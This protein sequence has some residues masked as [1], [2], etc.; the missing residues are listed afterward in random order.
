MSTA[1]RLHLVRHAETLFN[2]RRQL[3]GW[4]DSPLTEHGERQVAALGERMRDVPLTAAFMSD[5]T[6]TRTTMAAALRHHPSIEPVPLVELREWN[7]GGFEG[8][9]ND[10]LWDPVF[11]GLGADY[12]DV[13]GTWPA[14]TEN[15]F[16]SLLDAIAAA[17]PMGRA[18]TGVQV[19]ERIESGLATV[20]RA[21]ESGGDVLVVTH[22]SVM[23]SILRHLVPAHRMLPGFPNCGVV[24]VEWADGAGTVGE[25]D[26]SCSLPE[27]AAAAR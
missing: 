12:A 6:R 7:F 21:V 2:I 8:Q 10:S 4:C 24:T 14:M 26:A 5:L 23:Q 18:E 22:G 1:A 16:D 13:P 3:Q 11:S 15:G 17:D 9:P 27:P 20:L 25:V 19:R